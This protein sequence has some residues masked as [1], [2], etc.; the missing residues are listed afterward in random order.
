MRSNVPPY[1]AEN[2]KLCGWKGITLGRPTRLRNSL[3][4]SPIFENLPQPSDV[5]LLYKYHTT[6][7]T[8]QY[9]IHNLY[10]PQLPTHP[11]VKLL[12]PL[13]GSMVPRDNNHV[14]TFRDSLRSI[15]NE[16][17]KYQ[18]CLVTRNQLLGAHMELKWFF[19]RMEE[20][21]LKECVQYKKAKSCWPKP[22]SSNEFREQWEP[23]LDLASS[24]AGLRRECLAPSGKASMCWGN[25]KVQYY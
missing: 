24:G 25:D 18:A 17:G 5:H 6:H 8:V 16:R 20:V 9:T 2:V 11:S 21:M 19:A 7:P 4:L 3:Q 12:P 1:V 22:G 23:F 13:L 15:D 14:E 10:T